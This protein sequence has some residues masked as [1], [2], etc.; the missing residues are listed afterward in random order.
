MGAD[1]VFQGGLVAFC[2]Q[3]P[4]QA[5]R[6]HRL[7]VTGLGVERIGG[8][9]RDLLVTVTAVIGVQAGEQVGEVGDLVVLGINVELGGDGAVG[10][11]VGGQQVRGLA[12]G[13]AR[14]TRTSWRPWPVSS[15]MC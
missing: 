15:V 12:A 8:D 13:V 11:V 3:H 14:M 9:Q 10:D 1:L 2:Y 5:C 7:D 6:V 4:V